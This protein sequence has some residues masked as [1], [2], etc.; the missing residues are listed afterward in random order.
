[1]RRNRVTAHDC[2]C[3][4][5]EFNILLKIFWIFSKL[6]FQL[7]RINSKLLFYVKLNLLDSFFKYFH[8]FSN[9]GCK[10]FSLFE[11]DLSRCISRYITYHF[12]TIFKKHKNLSF[13]VKLHPK[14]SVLQTVCKTIFFKSDPLA[15]KC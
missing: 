9:L 11:I 15:H 2:F 14:V 10:C 13:V 12:N 6:L 8:F 1:M 7:F 3:L 4:F 5:A